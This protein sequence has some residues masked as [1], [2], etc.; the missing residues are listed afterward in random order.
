[1]G[2]RRFRAGAADAPV[3]A[4]TIGTTARAAIAGS[5]SVR[6][7]LAAAL[8]LHGITVASP[9]NDSAGVADQPDALAARFAESEIGPVLRSDD[10]VVGDRDRTRRAAWLVAAVAAAM[11]V[12][13]AGVQYWGVHRRLRMVE[14][15]RARLRSALASTLVGRTTVDAVYAEL[16][17]L[18]QIERSSPQWSTVIAALTQAVPEEAHL[19]AIRTR[20][21]SLVVDGLADHAARVFDALSKTRGLTEVKSASAVHR[22]LQDNGSA[23]EHFTIAA[24]APVLSPTQQAK[25]T[26]L[27]TSAPSTRR[28]GQ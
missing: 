18:S 15:E 19:T 5:S 28:P 1:M 12:G 10:A 17:Q 26:A 24:R 13:A 16:G 11:L 14:A 8:G 22:E 2:V 4:D 27:P 25:P 3:I 21:D 9:G 23:K 7:E 6:K 20:D